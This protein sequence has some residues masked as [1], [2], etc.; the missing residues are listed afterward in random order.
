MT[1]TQKLRRTAEHVRERVPLQPQI[2]IIL[3]SGLSPVADALAQDGELAYADLP[4]FPVTGVAGHR[5]RL[6]LGSMA[7]TPVA[8]FEGRV[9]SY[10]G[11]AMEEVAYSTYLAK[12]L[13]ARTLIVTNAAGSINAAFAAGDIM[14]IR[15][16]INLLGTNPLVGALDDDL[17]GRFVAMRNAY[18]AGLRDLARRVARQNGFTVKEGVY[19]ATSGPMYETDAEIRMLAILGADVV[20]MS[21]VPEV[22]AARRCAMRVLGI[23]VI[24]NQ[25]TASGASDE[26]ALTHAEV[27]RVVT[28]SADRVKRLIL[29]VS[30]SI[31]A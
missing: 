28:S 22:I 10:E 1:L 24:A 30:G 21:T 5:G 25:T 16:H 8:V 7:G 29:G 2:A 14:L 6:L 12:Q 17:G 20:G 11:R 19:A 18:D 13:G 23:S 4:H 31:A 3:G 15:D 9:H 26:V 27:L